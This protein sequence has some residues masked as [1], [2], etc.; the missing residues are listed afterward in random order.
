MMIKMAVD[1]SD[2]KGINAGID[3]LEHLKARASAPAPDID[4]IIGAVADP[5]K[6]GEGRLGYMADVAVAGD[7]GAEISKLME[8]HFDG[9][10]Q[11]MGGT[12]SSIEKTWR[13]QGG[14]A[15]APMLI[16]DSADG[17]R[18]VMI[19]EARERVKLCYDL[20]KL[21]QQHNEK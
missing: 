4:K 20:W 13:A 1:T 10:Y 16:E 5:Y 7:S 11:K 6:Y 2:L 19:P 9:K 17:S 8:G 21:Q 15:I 18:H 3:V 14:L 12:H